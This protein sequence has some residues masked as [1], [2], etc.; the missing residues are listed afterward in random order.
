MI[1]NH[2]QN[3]NVNNGYWKT[4]QAFHNQLNNDINN[5]QNYGCYCYLDGTHHPAKGKYQDIFD[6]VCRNL[7]RGYDCIEFDDLNEREEAESNDPSLDLDDDA[8]IPWLVDY[9]PPEEGDY[10]GYDK[11][12]ELNPND[13]CKQ[14]TCIVETRFAGH[15]LDLFYDE[16]TLNES[17][18]HENDFYPE[19]TC[20]VKPGRADVV[21]DCC[22]NYPYRLPYRHKNNDRMCCGN[23]VYNPVIDS[24]CE[25]N[26]GFVDFEICPN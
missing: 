14:R 17:L 20:A 25:S 9:T 26:S 24:C 10:W 12:E 4:N 8:C 23:S 3:N 19:D 1:N 13:I 11:C 15:L 18:F 16:K 21:K 6:E 5:L 7:V 2:F 22:G